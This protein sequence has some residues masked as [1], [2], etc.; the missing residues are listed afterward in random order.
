MQAG[1]VYIRGGVTQI[2]GN[3]GHGIFARG[4]CGAEDDNCDG[5]GIERTVHVTD[6][7]GW[8]IRSKGEVR[9]GNNKG[10][11]SSGLN[12]VNNN[13]N[14]PQCFVARNVASGNPAFESE[15]CEGGGILS[16]GTGEGR[17]G[18]VI[19][20]NLEVVG[21]GATG[22]LAMNDV[23]LTNSLD[24]GKVANNRGYGIH[25]EAGNVYIDGGFTR[26][27]GNLG[28]GIFSDGGCDEEDDCFGLS[29][30][31]TLHVLNN[32]GWGIRSNGNI[33]IGN[34]TG[35]SSSGLNKVNNNGNGPQ[36][37]VAAGDIESGLP[38][39]EAEACEGGGI[40]ALGVN[41]AEGDNGG[42]IAHNLEVV[43]NGTTGI[44]AMDDIRL[45]N[46]LDL[47]KVADNKG[48]GIH[49]EGNVYITGGFTQI[50]GNKGT[51]IFAGGG[52][53]V[54]EDLCFGLGAERTLHVLNNAGWGIR[55]EGRVSL[56][57]IKRV[58]SSG[59]NKV[60]GNGKGDQ[61]FV[62]TDIESGLPDFGLESCSGGGIL[63]ER[64]DP[65]GTIIAH[66]LQV[67]DNGC[68]GVDAEENVDIVIGEICRNGGDGIDAGSDVTLQQVRVCDNHANGVEQGAAS[69]SQSPL[70]EEVLGPGPL[71]Q[72]PGGHTSIVGSFLSGNTGGGVKVH[73]GGAVLIEGSN[74]VGN[75][76]FGVNNLNPNVDVDARGN[77]WGDASG[78]GGDGP[79][80]GNGVNGGVDFADWSTQ[81]IALTVAVNPNS[82]GVPAGQG[83]QIRL[84]VQSWDRPDDVV[85]VAIT[86]PLGWVDGPLAFQM[87]LG[88][89]SEVDI[90][91]DV[92]VDAPTGTTNTVTFTAV[93]TAGPDQTGDVKAAII[94]APSADLA[95]TKALSKSSLVP[96]RRQVLQK[97]ACF[98][99]R[100]DPRDHQGGYP[101]LQVLFLSPVVVLQVE[102]VDVRLTES[103]EPLL[104]L[105]SLGSNPLH[106]VCQMDASQHPVHPGLG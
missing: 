100:V 55:S 14:G 52:C 2:V 60:N 66:N 79:G 4:E 90:D 99:G 94:V 71:G 96:Q 105:P 101:V 9:I 44:L 6:N 87:D 67:L 19:A 75:T 57:N 1:N 13:G 73:T 54:D 26:I 39:F 92:P 56:G 53:D 51:G 30:E 49:S 76:G 40:L 20:H 81:V 97:L 18:G 10:V 95:V 65:D 27:A 91:V 84:Y 8:G 89:I 68:N 78:P 85:D 80:T 48:Y 28:S 35:V 16:Y 43:G 86:D 11:S 70:P 46:S 38:D 23:R 83:I 47:G 41:D 104:G 5:V 15:E 7:A 69:E 103:L 62:A 77:W 45:I 58:S 59:Q 24:L 72:A 61:C 32:G 12:L 93:S 50:T 3:D 82:S 63:A 34:D 64:D 106:L 21:N 88:D 31:R 22:I 36:C 98:S 37:F 102:S 17:N 74:F 33:S 25:A 29:T 42:I